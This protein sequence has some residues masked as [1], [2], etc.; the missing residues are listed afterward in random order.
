M[1]ILL[2]ATYDEAFDPNVLEWQRS[3][4]PQECGKIF[5]QWLHKHRS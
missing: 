3:E 5:F 4:W 1:N 2:G